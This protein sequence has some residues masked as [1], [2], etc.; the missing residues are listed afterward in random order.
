MTPSSSTGQMGIQEQTQK[1]QL[2][3]K[4]KRA[5]ITSADGSSIVADTVGIC[6]QPCLR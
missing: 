2:R 6:I 4:E 3:T 5:K 1:F